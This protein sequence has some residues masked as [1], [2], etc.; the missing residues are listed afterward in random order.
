MQEKESIFRQKSLDRVSSPE[1]TDDY[2][3][4]IGVG[5]GLVAAAF[6]LLVA[7]AVIWN[8]VGV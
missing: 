7:A 6:A 2:M 5:A 1:E 8:V 3:K 4:V